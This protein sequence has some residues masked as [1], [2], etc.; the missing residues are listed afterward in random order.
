M[1]CYSPRIRSRIFHPKKVLALAEFIVNLPTGKIDPVIN[2]TLL[3]E[4]IFIITTDD[5][6]Y[7]YILTYLCTH[8]SAHHLTRDD[9]WRICHQA[10]HYLLIGNILYKRGVETIL[11]RCLIHDEV[12]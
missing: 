11:H 4:H 7:G 8:R 12:E 1:D 5:S 9:R 3:V 10:Q 6:W 2:E